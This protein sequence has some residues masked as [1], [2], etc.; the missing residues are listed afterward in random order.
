MFL[1]T[2]NTDKCGQDKLLEG[3]EFQVRNYGLFKI[4]S[5]KNFNR[6]VRYLRF[7][8]METEGEEEGETVETITGV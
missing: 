2:V 3:Q 8:L 4:P 6:D 5:Q 7:A 1:L